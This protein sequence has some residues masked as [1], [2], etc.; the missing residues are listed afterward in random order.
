MLT[1]SIIFPNIPTLTKAVSASRFGIFAS[2]LAC[3]CHHSASLSI[4][5][6]AGNVGNEGAQWFPSAFTFSSAPSPAPAPAQVFSPA[7]APGGPFATLEACSAAYQELYQKTSGESDGG[8]PQNGEPP[9]VGRGGL[10][11]DEDGVPIIIDGPSGMARP[12][13]ILYKAPPGRSGGKGWDYRRHGE[14]WVNL[15]NCAGPGQ[16]PVDLPRYVSVKGQTKY[17]LWFDYMLDPSLT[18]STIAKLINDGHGLRYDVAS[19]Q[20]DLGFVKIGSQEYS[21][22][23]YTFHA[24][25]E[26]TMTG[27]FFP[28]ELQIYNKAPDGNIVAIALLFREGRSNPLLAA[29]LSATGGAAPIWTMR[30]RSGAVKIRGNYSRAFNLADL[31]PKGGAARERSFF[32]YEGSLTQPPCTSGVDWWVLSSPIT[33]SR[34]EINFVRRGIF[35]SRSTKH[36]NARATLPLGNRTVLS[37]MVGIQQVSRSRIA[38]WVSLDMRVESRNSGDNPSQGQVRSGEGEE[39]TEVPFDAKPT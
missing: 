20:V 11:D 27:A 26:H 38:K 3:C 30:N 15:G 31:L 32:N 2:L 8:P 24:P 37:G 29:L 1:S 28:L 36:G 7:P 13:K 39:E 6:N 12:E 34:E 10:A 35:G 9:W 4:A 17:V 19:N 5:S 22:A 25:S 23:E 14:D 33:A 18:N 16:S 21:A